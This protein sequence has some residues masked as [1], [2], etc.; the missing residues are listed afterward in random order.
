MSMGWVC[1]WTTASNS[2]V[3]QPPDHIHVYEYVE[4]R[5][6]EA[7]SGNRRTPRKCCPSAILSTTS[8]TC[9]D[10]GANSG[11]FCKRP[12]T[13]PPEPWY[14]RQGLIL[15][16]CVWTNNSKFPDLDQCCSS[17]GLTQS[18]SVFVL[19]RH[20]SFHYLSSMLQQL[21][22]WTRTICHRGIVQVEHLWTSREVRI[23]NMFL[24]FILLPNFL[25]P[26]QLV[27]PLFSAGL[28]VCHNM[29]LTYS[30]LCFT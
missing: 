26:T 19:C 7:D 20:N 17:V 11:L 21:P 10:P 8:S 18:V 6:N 15:F 16:Q 3:G 2:P 24:K 13:V 5:W 1:L 27:F 23:F 22:W 4:P 29:F 14:G 9:T 25:T 12:V 28:S 30:W